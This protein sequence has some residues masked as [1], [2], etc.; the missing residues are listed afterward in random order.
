MTLANA[1]ADLPD[2]I[3]SVV[4]LVNSAP[5]KRVGKAR[6]YLFHVFV[7]SPRQP[8]PTYNSLIQQQVNLVGCQ[9]RGVLY[10]K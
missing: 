9:L 2:W 5:P 3:G 6:D 10:G 4:G 7:L 8:F 1:I